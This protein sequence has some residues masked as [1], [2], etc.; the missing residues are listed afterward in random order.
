MAGNMSEK[1]INFSSLKF[2]ILCWFQTKQKQKKKKKSS[3]WLEFHVL[4]GLLNM[5]IFVGFYHKSLDIESFI[6]NL[7]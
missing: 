4:T 1:K 5:S 3:Y 7:I 6:E 2:L